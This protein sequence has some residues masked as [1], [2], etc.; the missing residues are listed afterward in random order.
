[1]EELEFQEGTRGIYI[2]CLLRHGYE[3]QMGADRCVSSFR[4]VFQK[5]TRIKENALLSVGSS[6][7]SNSIEQFG[8]QAHMRFSWT[9]KMPYFL[10]QTSI[11][12]HSD[13]EGWVPCSGA[14]YQ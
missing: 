9:V 8:L 1:M 11:Y 10:H 2:I 14:C 5:W 7:V 4:S 12:Q 6:A 13:G 3:S